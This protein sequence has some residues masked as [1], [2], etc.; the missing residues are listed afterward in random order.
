MYWLAWGTADRAY[1]EA[2]RYFLFSAVVAFGF[3][4]LIL[5]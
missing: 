5:V 1:R 3:A 2:L 4:L